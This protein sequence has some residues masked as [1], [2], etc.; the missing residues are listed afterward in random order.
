MFTGIVED[1]G[2]IKSIEQQ[3]KEKL[4]TIAVSKIDPSELILG[5]SVAVNGTCLTIKFLK[6]DGF[7]VET[8]HETLLKTNLSVLV[9]GDHVNLERS[10]RVG[11]RLSGHIVTGHVDG[12][13]K[14]ESRK[15]I[16]KSVEFHFSVTS[17][18]GKYIIKKGS[19]AVDGVSLTV[20]TVLDSTFSV[21]IIPYTL[22][23]TTFQYMDVGDLVNIECD[24]IGKYV[25]RLLEYRE[26]TPP[27]YESFEI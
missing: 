15:E 7:V 10:L 16:G 26:A 20:N 1:I 24:I 9:E 21:N 13:G 25:E 22:Q 18:L 6:E 19:I 5:E 4:F 8:S 14:V 2:V 12:V 27:T 17:S 23:E 11:D 3:G